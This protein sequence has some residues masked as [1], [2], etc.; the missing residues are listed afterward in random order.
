MSFLFGYLSDKLFT[1]S[2]TPEEIQFSTLSKPLLQEEKKEENKEEEKKEKEEKTNQVNT[3]N[4]W[5]QTRKRSFTSFNNSSNNNTKNDK[6]KVVIWCR[7][8]T[9]GQQSGTSLQ[10]QEV[11]CRKYCS[12]QHL[13][14]PSVVYKLVGS[15][16]S[17]SSEIKNALDYID[18]MLEQGK[19]VVIVAHMPDR[20]MRRQ[21]LAIEYI[22]KLNESEG[23]IHFVKDIEGKSLRSD[24]KV[25]YDKIKDLFKLAAA[26]SKIPPAK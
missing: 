22:D 1:S 14:D 26:E 17:V 6:T 3:F 7:I 11:E 4:E 9:E 16:Y 18:G 12:Q 15:G 21:A 13:P 25:G 10:M 24:T 8:S 2:L 20:F 19:K 5:N 23:C